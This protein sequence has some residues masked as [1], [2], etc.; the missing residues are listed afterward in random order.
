[1]QVLVF[2]VRVSLSLRWTSKRR[3]RSIIYLW[4]WDCSWLYSPMR[5]RHVR[6][7]VG[8]RYAKLV[9]LFLAACSCRR[10]RRSPSFLSCVA[11]MERIPAVQISCQPS[12]MVISH[13][14]ED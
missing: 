4:R 2:R 5:D 6:P 3:I 8:H 7:Q 13:C 1:M 9:S 14:F 12:Y 11:C 10:R